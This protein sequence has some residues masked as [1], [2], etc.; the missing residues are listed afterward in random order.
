MCH[1]Y[2]YFLKNVTFPYRTSY[3][4]N[5]HMGLKSYIKALMPCTSEC[6]MTLKQV[7]KFFLKNGH[8]CCSNPVGSFNKKRK[9]EDYYMVL[10]V[11]RYFY[12]SIF[13]YNQIYVHAQLCLAPCEPRDCN[14]PVSSVHEVIQV[15]ILE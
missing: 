15:R 6:G 4:L 13:I 12:D 10:Y 8:Y 7:I 9:F 1:F 3:G 14:L 11:H 5:L 2:M